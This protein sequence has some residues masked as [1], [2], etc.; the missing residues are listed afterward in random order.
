MVNLSSINKFQSLGLQDLEGKSLMTRVDKK[1]LVSIKDFDNLMLDLENEFDVLEI[2]G[3]R[4][5]PYKTIYYDDA[6][7]NLYNH[8]RLKKPKR[9]KLRERI[10]EHSG[11]GYF[12]IKYKSKGKVTIKERIALVT[13]NL[14]SNEDLFSNEVFLQKWN[15][16]FADYKSILDIYYKRVTF[17]SKT[18]ECRVTMDFNL[19]YK[20]NEKLMLY[21]DMIVVEIKSNTFNDKNLVTSNL[22]KIGAKKISF[23]KYGVGL[24]LCN[25]NLNTNGFAKQLAMLSKFD[26]IKNNYDN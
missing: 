4:F 23:S 2:D 11:N 7:F 22:K 17:V 6:N 16:N 8:A 24:A 9:F 25:D 14:V 5:L 20:Y 26:D 3:I 10:Y 15:I 13:Q 19:K 12:E 21:E 1:Y 18:S